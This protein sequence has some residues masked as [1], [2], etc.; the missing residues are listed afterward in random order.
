MSWFNNLNIKVKI[1]TLVG[2]LFVALLATA[3][4]LFNGINKIAESEKELAEVTIPAI[5][6]AM[7]A[8]MMHDGL[9]GVVYSALLAADENNKEALVGA[10]KDLQEN[11]ATF[12][13]AIANL[14][15]LKLPSDVAAA[16]AAAEPA[17]DAYLA[18]SAAIVEAASQGRVSDIAKMIE[19]FEA[20]FGGLEES[21]GAFGDLLE[22][23]AEATVARADEEIVVSKRTGTLTIVVSVVVGL[24][25]SFL[26]VGGLLKSL[27]GI[28]SNLEGESAGLTEASKR[29]LADANSLSQSSAEQAAALQETAASIEEITAMVKKSEEGA[30]ELLESTKKSRSAADKGKQAVA[31]ARTAM[32]KIN[33]GNEA[34][35]SEV[36][37]S[38]QRI[39][40]I[41]K[42]I[43]EI[44]AKT[45]VINDIVFQTKLLSFNASVEA[46]RAGEH[47]KGFAVVAEEVGNLAQMSGNAAREIADMLN[48]GIA[49]VESIVKE[50]RKSVENIMADGKSRVAQGV[51]VVTECDTSLDQIVNATGE[52]GQKVSEI[53]TAIR[54]Q[55]QG[56]GEIS[57]AVHQLDQ[58]TQMNLGLAEKSN[59]A[60]H[61]L[62]RRGDR[63]VEIVVEL[64]R[65]CGASQDSKQGEDWESQPKL[66]ESQ[67]TR[68]AQSGRIPKF[69]K[70]KSEKSQ[71]AKRPSQQQKKVASF[72]AASVASADSNE[73]PSEN[74]PR[75]QDF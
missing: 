34:I 6:N 49:R 25:L 65:I 41:T 73:V 32:N 9:R 43:S 11:T 14:K 45:K 69:E 51:Q 72:G 40:E 67:N 22:K 64:G 7:M 58:T 15:G 28:S 5:R 60:S 71:P 50:T 74:D 16:L 19:E 4:I 52:V 61:E 20:S 42:V 12:R 48:S 53:T 10:K 21:L 37:K 31:Q 39:T 44:G 27:L 13:E 46:A 57:K 33:E 29:P 62:V 75:F 18:K 17:L 26:I 55:R 2:A 8:D 54:E 63:L 3:G 23:T 24:L 38:N 56:I 59:K 66:V 70:F 47:G 1:Y 35:F 36:E 30:E 68:E